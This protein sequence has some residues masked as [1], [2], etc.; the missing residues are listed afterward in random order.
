MLFFSQLVVASFGLFRLASIAFPFYL[1]RFLKP[2]PRRD[3]S[4]IMYDETFF[5][6]NPQT[7]GL[8]REGT[9]QGK[10][11]KGWK[12]FFQGPGRRQKIFFLSLP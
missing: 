11:P 10:N 6:L 1:S 7:G 9:G 12:Y 3:M 4:L 5:S 2:G 8:W